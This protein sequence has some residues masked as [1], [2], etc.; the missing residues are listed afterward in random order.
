MT[1]ALGQ[2]GDVVPRWRGNPSHAGQRLRLLREAA[3]LSPETL[4]ARTGITPAQLSNI[5][6]G[7][8]S[9]L[10]PTVRKLSWAHIR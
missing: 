7:L 8:W 10:A 3:G 2:L 9:P 4:C 6:D 5:E 1:Q